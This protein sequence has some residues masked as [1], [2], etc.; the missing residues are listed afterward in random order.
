MD[1]AMMSGMSTMTMIGMNTET[2]IIEIMRGMN[3]DINAV[4]A[5]AKEQGHER[6]KKIASQKNNSCSSSVHF[7]SGRLKT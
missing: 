4:F 5:G 6:L 3:T 7:I 2:E 1:M